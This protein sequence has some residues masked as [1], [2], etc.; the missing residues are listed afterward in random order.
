MT[1][2]NTAS[3]KRLKKYVRP[4]IKT[5]GTPEPT[6][7]LRCTGYITDCLPINGIDCCIRAPASECD[8]EC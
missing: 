7:L 2:H 3:Q 6:V 5:V 1:S 4:Q 8:A